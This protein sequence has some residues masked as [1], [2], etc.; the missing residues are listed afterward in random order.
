MQLAV[1]PASAHHSNVVFDRNTEITIRGEVTRYIWRNP[2]VYLYVEAPNAAGGTT[3]WQLEADPTPI[4]AR[5][6]WAPDSLAPGDR[7]TIRAHPD[8]T[9]PDAH[10]LVVSLAT[11]GGALLTMRSGG[12][13]AAS[14]AESIAGVWD[15]LR[16]SFTRELTYGRLTEKGRA[17]QAVF[18]ESMNP[19][20]D[21]VPFP[22]PT[23]II[24]PYMSEVEI[25]DDRILMRS[26]FFNVERTIWM[27]GRGHPEGGEP[28]N[29]GH[30]IGRWE[31]DVLVVDTTLFTENIAGNRNGVPAGL[32]KR[33]VERYSLS[34]DRR[35]LSIEYVIDDPEYMIEPARGRMFWD[36]APDRVMQP[37]NCDRDNARLYA[38]D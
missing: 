22:L 37:F 8:R 28:T 38:I 23:I 17:A 24:A 35:R 31:D 5:S 20:I 27:D 3:E 13:G 4:M 6:G 32:Q 18:D 11:P 19:V 21:C 15:G 7:V 12:R 33:V 1:W 29:Q 34:E 36:Y 9:N 30:S 25:L 26:E 2:H 14:P 16:G 10:A